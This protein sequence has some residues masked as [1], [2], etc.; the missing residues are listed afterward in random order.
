MENLAGKFFV[1]YQADGPAAIDIKGH[2]LLILSYSEEDMVRELEILGGDEIREV[3]YIHDENELLA[4][5]AAEI[6][7]GVVLTPPG[8]SVATMIKSLE[9]ELPW[10]H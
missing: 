3:T 1:P 4:D 6:N 7:G 10:I 5:L 2:K 8:T 9:S